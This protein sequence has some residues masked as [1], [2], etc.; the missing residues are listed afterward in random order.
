MDYAVLVWT[1]FVFVIGYYIIYY[2][3]IV[4]SV[5][6]K[7]LLLHV[8]FPTQKLVQA[9]NNVIPSCNSISAQSRSCTLC[10]YIYIY[11]Y[12]NKVNYLWTEFWEH[13]T[14]HAWDWCILICHHSVEWSNCTYEE[15]SWNDAWPVIWPH[16]LCRAC[17]LFLVSL[18]WRQVGK[19]W[20]CDSLPQSLQCSF[21][22]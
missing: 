18:I 15:G 4:I 8:C 17:N 2:V 22:R 10:T 14:Q 6:S 5:Y 12:I 3:Q 21:S 16:D 20:G 1:I 9:F 13:C 19:H 7:W 11:I